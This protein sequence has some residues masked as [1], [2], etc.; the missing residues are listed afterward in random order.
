MVAQ[1]LVLFVEFI[2]SSALF[3][4]VFGVF[5]ASVGVGVLDSF[6]GHH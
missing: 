5:G 4:V 6:L 3:L 1:D 2:S